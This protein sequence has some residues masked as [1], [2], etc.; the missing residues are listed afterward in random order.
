MKRSFYSD[1]FS[2]YISESRVTRRGETGEVKAALGVPGGFEPIDWLPGPTNNQQP[3]SGKKP[4]ESIQSREN[5]CRILYLTYLVHTHT[6][7]YIYIYSC[8]IP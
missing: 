8:H 6:H 4:M 1:R 3:T 5:T 2:I 7:I